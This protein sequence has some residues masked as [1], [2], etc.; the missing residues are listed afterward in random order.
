M[1]TWAKGKINNSD[2]NISSFIFKDALSQTYTLEIT[3]HGSKDANLPNL[4]DLIKF[5]FINGQSQEID[6]SGMVTHIG[7]EEDKIQKRWNYNLTIAPRLQILK[8]NR[9]LQLYPDTSTIDV[10]QS[11]LI[12]AVK[13]LKTNQLPYQM[14]ISNSLWTSAFKRLEMSWANNDLEY[15][16]T[17]IQYGIRFYFEQ[18]DDGE[19]V[20]F[21]DAAA[22]LPK[23]DENL[24]FNP[25]KKED[26]YQDEP[27]IYKITQQKNNKNA[28]GQ[29]SFY[30]PTTVN[31]SII[32]LMQTR[33]NP[34]TQSPNENS[35]NPYLWTEQCYS[36]AALQSSMSQAIDQLLHHQDQEY[37]LYSYYSGLRVGQRITLENQEGFIETV[38]LKGSYENQKW[39]FDSEALFRPLN[40]KSWLGNFQ[41]KRNIPATLT[42]AEIQSDMQV[43]DLG[44]FR[45]KFP[46]RVLTDANND[47]WVFMRDL[48][49]TVTQGGGASHSMSGTAEVFIA[50]ENGMPYNWFIL[51]SL[52]NNT[53]PNI[54]NST[55][56][57]ESRINTKGGVN[58]HMRHQ[59]ASNPYSELNL[60]MT[61]SQ[62]NA[63]GLNLG[64]N[65]T[66]MSDPNSDLHGMQEQSIGYA[67][68]AIMGNY[69]DT[70]GDVENPVHQISLIQDPQTKKA[71]FKRQLNVSNGGTYTKN[72]YSNP[73]GASTQTNINPA[74]PNTFSNE[75]KLFIATVYGEAVGQGVL[76]WMAVAS[77]IMN[78]VGKYEWKNKCPTITAVIE[79]HAAFSSYY[80]PKIKSATLKF[81]L[82]QNY[83]NHPTGAP[84]NN[85][86]EIIQTIY[87][88]FNKVKKS[89]TTALFYYSPKES[90]EPKYIKDDLA[91]GRIVKIEV[92]G[93]SDDDFIFYTY[94][95]LIKENPNQ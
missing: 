54:V 22:K 28:K 65:L 1:L 43:N 94:T 81:K 3:C 64:T 13:A 71:S 20:I 55:N 59:D 83:L 36:P 69:Y 18:N 82:A 67:K 44:E 66:Q 50:S 40:A 49:G 92:N 8:L 30:D 76:A 27:Y 25:D 37:L 88:I 73:I 46:K 86:S 26:V 16:Q 51:G 39:R 24:N 79:D 6:I 95:S 84:P 35:G 75:F 74:Q 42:G 91:K 33:I 85:L 23:H 38:K 93:I 12:R 63:S 21:V 19:Q 5:S 4:L 87:P 14:Q 41:T 70:V 68:R 2:T 34:N 89:T 7:C 80:D 78:R 11:L 47:P 90:A 10:L 53:N 17:L 56:Y 15:L 32:N 29:G 48:Q 61:D 62:N 77:V 60:S 72:Y 57:R 52:S 31:I 9:N 58:I 45:V